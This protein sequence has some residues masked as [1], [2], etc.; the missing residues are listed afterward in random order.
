MRIPAL[1]LFAS[2]SAIAAPVA[3]PQT[4]HAQTAQ[5]KFEVSFQARETQRRATIASAMRFT[6]EEGAAFWPIYDVYRLAA[7]SHQLRRFMMIQR[8]SENT[9]EMDK[10]TAKMITSSALALEMEQVTAKQEY[11]KNLD[12]HFEGARY[13]R[14]YQL[15][16]K[17]DAIFRFGWTKQIP[18]AVT[19]EEFEILQ[20]RFEGA[21][22]EAAEA[23]AAA[24]NKSAI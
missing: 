18:L 24:A 21:Q 11:I 22:Q 14:L 2:L 9:I 23:A 19:E 4:A 17:L 10:A 6:E 3:L 1:L 12:E 5:D 13:F 16:T 15:E 8:L 7:K 20:Q